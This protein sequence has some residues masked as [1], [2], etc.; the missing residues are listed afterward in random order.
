MESVVLLNASPRG[1]R[2]SSNGSNFSAM[3]HGP[4]VSPAS[5][6]GCLV[7]F[8]EYRACEPSI[9]ASN[10]NPHPKAKRTFDHGVLLK[11]PVCSWDA[12]TIMN[13]KFT[14]VL[15]SRCRRLTSATLIH[16]D[17]KTRQIDAP[18]PALPKA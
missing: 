11:L 2:L 15:V 13:A 12:E 8:I 4:T 10:F 18:P 7:K 9:I 1:I 17:S 6:L 14:S 16:E 3:L 5:W